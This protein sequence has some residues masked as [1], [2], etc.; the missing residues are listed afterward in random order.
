MA[1]LAVARETCC[2]PTA[3]EFLCSTPRQSLRHRIIPYRAHSDS[4]QGG[5]VA[6]S[7]RFIEIGCKADVHAGAKAASNIE[8]QPAAQPAHPAQ[9][10][11][12]VCQHIVEREVERH[13][14]DGCGGLTLKKTRVFEL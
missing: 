1:R 7:G 11:V 8:R 14:A 5:Q 9:S 3:C 12:A 10:L 4:R 6:R 2:S 13:G